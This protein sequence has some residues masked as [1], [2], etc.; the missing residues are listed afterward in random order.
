M[1]SGREAVME[2][3]GQVP[4]VLHVAL[5]EDQLGRRTETTKELLGVEL[6]TTGS[7]DQ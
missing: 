2:A 7:V 6:H 4:A 3:R 5:S 1:A